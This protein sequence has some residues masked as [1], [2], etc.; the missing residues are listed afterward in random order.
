MSVMRWVTSRGK[1]RLETSTFLT[2]LFYQNH[3]FWWFS[4]VGGML[5][6]IHSRTKTPWTPPHFILQAP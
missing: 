3:R 2:A 5:Y 6:Q 1:V 4:F